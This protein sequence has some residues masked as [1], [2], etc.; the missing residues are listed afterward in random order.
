MGACLVYIVN[1]DLGTISGEV[2]NRLDRFGSERITI[3][4]K[5]RSCVAMVSLHTRKNWSKR[6]L[7]PRNEMN[8]CAP[9]NTPNTSTTSGHQCRSQFQQHFS[10]VRAG[11]FSRS[12][13]VSFIMPRV[14]IAESFSLKGIA[15]VNTLI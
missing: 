9:C 7:D 5:M 13:R 8:A 4:R 15:S 1:K 14:A 6:K 2:G 10:V 3:T 12:G 11:G